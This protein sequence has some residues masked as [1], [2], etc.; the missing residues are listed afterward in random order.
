MCRISTIR[1]VWHE[2]RRQPTV[3]TGEFL[4]DGR[5]L[6]E[7]CERATK[8]RFDLVSP[9][10]STAPEYQLAFAEQLLL[11]RPA[12]LASGRR[13]LLVCSQCADLSCGCISASI[14]AD[15]D[16]FIWDEIGYE[17]N[18]DGFSL[19]IFPMGRMVFLKY[20]L[21]RIVEDAISGIR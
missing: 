16:Y 1:I 8:Q 17:I 14:T 12:E 7:H 21:H 15:G 20:D 19:Q 10:G 2:A 9:F 13:A 5:T 4:I 18:D 3:I 11:K 6:L